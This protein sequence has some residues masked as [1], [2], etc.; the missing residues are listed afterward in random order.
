M[1]AQRDQNHVTVGQ[2]K[3]SDDTT[4]LSLKVDPST[5]YLLISTT[6]DAIVAV[7]TTTVKRDQN[8]RPTYYGVSSVD[9]VTPVPIRTD[10]DG[11]LLLDIT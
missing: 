11:R 7:P 8:F 5:N 6:G 3:A 1:E 2:G 10:D 4:T 9:G